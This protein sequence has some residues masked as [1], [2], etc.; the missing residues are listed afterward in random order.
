M[1][2]GKRS[3][4][5]SNKNNSSN[6]ANEV[7]IEIKELELDGELSGNVSGG[8]VETSSGQGDVLKDGS[9]RVS[10]TGSGDALDTTNASGSTNVSDSD[11]SQPGTTN[12][13]NSSEEME[14]VSDDRGYG[15]N[16]ENGNLDGDTKEKE[17]LKDKVDNLKEKANEIKNAPE[18]IKNKVNDTKE[19]V[20]N[21]KEKIKNAPEKMK[22]KADRAKESWQNRPRSMEEVKDR[23]KNS[24][25]K[26]KLKNRAKNAAKNA[27]NKAKDGAKDAFDNSKLGRGIQKA[28]NT[29]DNAKKAVKTTKKVAK[30]IGKAGKAA[31]NAARGL[32]NLIISTMP[33]SLI[34]IGVVLLIFLVIVLIGALS[35]G[36]GDNVNDSE[37]LTN[38][39]KADQKTLE[40]MQEYFKKYSNADGTLAMAVVLYPYYETLHDGDVSSYLYSV[41]DEEPEE[42]EDTTSDDE[43][44]SDIEDSEDIEDE[45]N[46]YEE[47]DIYLQP[48]RKYKIRKKLKNVL[49]KLNNSNEDEFKKYLKEKY[50]K[51]DKG[52]LGYD[53]DAYNG[54]KEMFDTIE[55]NKRDEFADIVIANIYD[56]KELFINYVYE[57]YSCTSDLQSAG[58]VEIDDM[59]KGNILVD[60][61]VPSCTSASNVWSCESMYPAP[62]TLKQYTL[63]GAYA[64]YS[65]MDVEKT[66]A[67]MLAIKS[68]IVDRSKS[69]GWGIKTDQ[70][71]NYVVTARN[72]TNDLVYCDIEAGCNGAVK[73]GTIS[74]QQRDVYE[75]AWE[76]IADK[77]IYD[78]DAKKTVGA[79]CLSRSGVCD[80]CKKGSCL[81][82]QELDNY[83]NTSYDTIIGMQYSDYAMI[84]VEG[85]FANVTIAAGSNCSGTTALDID[86]SNFVY[87]AQTDYENVGFCG[88]TK[89]GAGDGL[90][91]IGST[92][93][94]SGC[95]LT[96]VAMVTATLTQNYSIN[97]LTLNN[98]VRVGTDCGPGIPGSNGG[99]MFPYVASKYGLSVTSKTVNS[100]TI[101]D[102]KQ[103]I[104]EGGLIIA[105]VCGGLRWENKT[106]TKPSKS[107]GGHFIVVRGYEGD[108]V[109][110]SDPYQNNTLKNFSNCLVKKDGKCIKHKL[111]FNTFYND[112]RVKNGYLYII[113]GQTPFYELK[114]QTNVE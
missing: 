112:L 96:S 74:E 76:K 95:G 109:V 58:T 108:S 26:D 40:K 107:C 35:P 3:Y 99:S 101:N 69:M 57:A 33:W 41:T 36:N 64:E 78:K 114:N 82:H 61:K 29:V 104:D 45:E 50:F 18:N 6:S 19:K 10:D 90:C 47:N 24:D 62:I 72:N 110:I 5:T 55:K 100:N 30:G 93:C 54:Y 1:N 27:A 88:R 84:Q 49:K 71:G 16:Q 23:I 9:G 13:N 2:D 68:F 63:G 42:I 43:G 106:Y 111:D 38:Y 25:L 60:V 59:L 14:D 4:F 22:E 15:S 80:F 37:N 73:R 75:K 89:G 67:Q 94:T 66:A 98:E 28:K 103:G 79:F 91:P 21:A 105:S 48:F 34:A 31:V 44:D 20:N 17:S 87:Y 77:Y 11:Y 65:S 113:K 32:L 39:S 52:Y 56:N 12:S 83:T 85:D 81:A 97:P 8:S 51:Q 46:D 86:D 102:I 7:E 70:N 92:I 53:G